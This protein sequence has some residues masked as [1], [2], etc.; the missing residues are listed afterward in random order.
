M[1]TKQR[2]AAMAASRCAMCSGA[3]VIKLVAADPGHVAMEL[4]TCACAECGHSQT[5]S[6]DGGSS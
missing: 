3:M 1:A 5:Y 6:V 2:L 4:R